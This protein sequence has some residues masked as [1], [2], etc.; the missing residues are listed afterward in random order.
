MALQLFIDT[1]VYLDFF[2]HTN[3]D[4]ASLGKLEEHIKSGDIVLHLPKQVLDEF[5]RNRDSKLQTALSEFKGAKFL[6]AI[7]RH[8][9]S[10]SM[11]ETYANA[12][13]KA[14]EAR[15]VL[16][17]EAVA[18][19]RL[20]KLDVDITLDSIFQ[21]ATVHAHDDSL[22]AKGKLR[23]ERGNPPGK[24]GSLGDQYNWE[25]LL[26]KLPD[27]DLYIVSKDGD[28]ASNLTEKSN[29]TIYPNSVLK[30]E[31][32]SMKGGKSVYIFDTIKKVLTYYVKTLAVDA[33]PQADKIPAVEAVENGI[34]LETEVSKTK[35]AGNSSNAATEIASKSTVNSSDASGSN[36]PPEKVAL[37]QDAQSAKNAAIDSLVKS[38]N[39]ASTHAAIKALALYKNDF[40]EDEVNILL[41]AALENNQIR[42]I[43]GD[44]DVSEFYLNLFTEYLGEVD[45]ELLVDIIE[46]LGLVGEDPESDLPDETA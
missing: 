46:L 26:D 18:N 44:E 36:Q 17:A 10:L 12:I 42:W 25:L 35:A 22:F 21:C 29:G 7:P 15:D 9:Q 32:N 19:A 3:D 43:I 11:A 4:L 38:W 45:N 20:S 33:A 16:I 23:A 24:T 39:F 5:E 41:R 6:T 34:S 27:E 37:T 14:R 31:W 40:T 30:R 1:N 8:M 2:H 13:K 28:Y